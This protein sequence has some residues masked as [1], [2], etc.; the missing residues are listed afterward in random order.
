[1]EVS[2]RG[3][4][5]SKASGTWRAFSSA[6]VH[7]GGDLRTGEDDGRVIIC[8]LHFWSF[9]LA[10]GSCVQVPSMTLKSYP[11]RIEA[12]AVLIELESVP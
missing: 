7:R 3:L 10:A 5:L 2:H 4:L 11:L 12:D 8:P 1:M 6:C 9:E